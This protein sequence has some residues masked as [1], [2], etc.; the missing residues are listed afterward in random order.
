MD[1]DSQDELINKNAALSKGRRPSFVLLSETESS[2]SEDDTGSED[3]DDDTE[4]EG[5]EDDNGESEDEDLDF[6]DD[7]EE[8]EE[9]TEATVKGLADS[10]KLETHVRR[11]GVSSDEDGETCPICLNTFTD[12]PVGTPENCSHFFCLDCIVEWSKNANSCPVDRICFNYIII[13]AHFG[14]KIL[15]KV[16]LM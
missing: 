11:V 1:D 12:Q 2:S 14:G 16:L 5:G 15:E 4:E 9:E 10:Q 8:E 6:E 13:R 3:E 7:D